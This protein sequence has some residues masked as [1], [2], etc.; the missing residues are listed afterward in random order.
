MECY[1]EIPDIG[2]LGT[3]QIRYIDSAIIRSS[4][5]RLSWT[6]QDELSVPGLN[7]GVDLSSN[8]VLQVARGG[9]AVLLHTP[10]DCLGST[11]IV[12]THHDNDCHEENLA[13]S[14]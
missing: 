3:N 7:F 2:R 5:K 6:I 8:Q 13:V 1:R 11:S 10:P 9:R 14:L 12:D 4:Q